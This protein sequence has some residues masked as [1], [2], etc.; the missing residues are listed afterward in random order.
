MK[1]HLRTCIA[2]ALML[3]CGALAGEP[4]MDSW[5]LVTND[6]QMAI[7]VV[8][9]GSLS[10]SHYFVVPGGT[11]QGGWVSEPIVP[12]T[13]LKPGEPFSLLAR[14]RNLSTNKTFSFRHDHIVPGVSLD[15]D[16]VVISPSGMDMSPRMRSESREFGAGSYLRPLTAE[17]NQTAQFEFPLS[18]L[19][20]LEKIGTYR[21]TATKIAHAEKVLSWNAHVYTIKAEKEFVLTSNTLCVRVV[22]GK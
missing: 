1:T 19:C 10:R 21:I 3:P 15:L 5:G 12:K 14:I 18:E 13:D 8:A 2:L 22:P 4:A 6:V 9:P 20:K 7:S 17:P 16:C 11:N